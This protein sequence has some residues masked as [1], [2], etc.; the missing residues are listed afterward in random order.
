VPDATLTTPGP[1]PSSH[2]PGR[3]APRAR[4]TWRGI[5]LSEWIRLTTTRSTWVTLLATG[6]L[7]GLFG[8]VA[9]A[10]S[11]GAVEGPGGAAP[12]GFDGADTIG[13]LMAGQTPG[14][15]VIGV[16]GV[17]LGAREH[18][19]G[20]VRTTYSAVPRRWRV[21]LA[22]TLVLAATSAVVVGAGV[23]LAFVAGNAVLAGSDSTTV[24][25]DDEGTVRVLLGVTGYLVAAGVLGLF[26]GTLA[27]GVGA[28]VGTLIGLLLVVPGFGTLLL[29]D[30]WQDA[31]AYLPSEAA[32]SVT[33]SAGGDLGTVAGVVVLV[34]WVV[35]LGTAA[36]VALHRRD[37]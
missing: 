19:S 33:T 37:V 18:A 1:A 12:P 10:A 22:R 26:L 32:A 5:L 30:D 6:L 16:L 23:A 34:A 13:V 25:L 15:L 27:R 8:A 24:A 28:G 31:L 3:T 14:V 21:L 20:M 4:L 11:T 17:M 9:A 7:M 2:H 29:P 36:G 35:G